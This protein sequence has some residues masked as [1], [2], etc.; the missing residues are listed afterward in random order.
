[1]KEITLPRD[2]EVER[3][4]LGSMLRSI[5]AVNEVI[6]VVKVT[7]FFDSSHQKIYLAMIE[8][9]KSDVAIEPESIA[10]ELSEKDKHLIASVYEIYECGVTFSISKYIK[11]LLDFSRLRKF[12]KITNDSLS[13]VSQENLDINEF[14][15]GYNRSLDEIAGD[16]NATSL[17]TVANILENF[18]E[19]GV[20]ILDYVEGRQELYRSGKCTLR[21]LKTGYKVLDSYLSGLCPGHMI[22][23]A[24]RPGVGKS[25]FAM[26]IIKNLIE[27]EIPVLF[28]SMEMTASEVVG[29]TVSMK[30]HVPYKKFSDG[31]LKPD[32]YQ[33]VVESS[34]SLQKCPLLIDDEGGL[35]TT[36]IRTRVRRAIEA[37]G[38]RAVFIDYL[39]CIRP[40]KSNSREEGFREVSAEIRN[41][42]KQFQIPFFC[43]AQENRDSEKTETKRAPKKSDLGQT[44][45]IEQDA[46]SIMILRRPEL[47]DPYDRPGLMSCYIVK[48]RF[49]QEGKIDFPFDGSTGIVGEFDEDFEGKKDR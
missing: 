41:M 10:F 29:K 48:N 24:A 45:G 35:T 42:A 16:S 3:S 28:F 1:M 2:I 9:Y 17:R 6:D 39:T 27:D 44:G 5:D 8:S 49:G 47:D 20:N 40:R 32:Q 26:N 31:S 18:E 15:L 4:I 33:S 12:I 46:H 7:D 38:V 21:G 22:V 43:I 19:D 11:R 34:V 14:F 23:V 36:M 30:S 37:H 13:R 25:T